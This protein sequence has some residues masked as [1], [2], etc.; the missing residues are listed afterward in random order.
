MIDVGQYV[1]LDRQL[2][3][4]P[5]TEHL[6][7]ESYKKLQSVEAGQF[8][9]IEVSPTILTIKEDGIRSTM[10]ADGTTVTSVAKETPT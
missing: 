8:R 7:S 5:A 4:T 2:M 10:S 3:T 9:L 6:A 1:Y